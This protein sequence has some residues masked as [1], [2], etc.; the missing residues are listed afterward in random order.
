MSKPKYDPRS[1]LSKDETQELW[2]TGQLGKDPEFAKSVHMDLKK[3]FPTSMRLPK[4][5]V[6]SL[7]ILAEESG[8]PY[9]T[10]VKMVLTK[11]VK[12]IRKSA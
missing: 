3:S 9:Q 12:R 6:D 5:L 1:D 11:H 7:K 4:E 10:Y 8:I 2:E